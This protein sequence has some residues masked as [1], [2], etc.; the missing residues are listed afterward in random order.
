MAYT[1]ISC[2]GTGMFLNKSTNEKEYRET[3]YQFPNGNKKTTKV[4]LEALVSC[5]YRNF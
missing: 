5:S 3:T 1:L 2:V 4:F